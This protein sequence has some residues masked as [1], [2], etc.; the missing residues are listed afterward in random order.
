MFVNHPRIVAAAVL[1]AMAIGTTAPAYAQVPG[2]PDLPVAPPGA[3]GEVLDP[4]EDLIGEITGPLGDLVGDVPLDNAVTLMGED[5]VEAAVALS[6]I[7]FE[8]SEFAFI[9]RDDVFADTLSS[10]AG[11]G[12]A[13]APLLLT[14]TDAVDDRTVAELDRLGVTRV[15]LLGAGQALSPFVQQRFETAYGADNVTRIG[16]PSRIETAA[17]LAAEL[18]PSTPH[19]VMLRAYPEEGADQSQAYAD[20]LSVGPLASSLELPSLLTTTDYLHPATRAYL[21]SAGV[22][23]VTMIGGESAIA[24]AVEQTLSSMGITVDRIAGETRWSTSILVANAMG[25]LDASEANRIILTEGGS[26]EQPLWAAG[27]AAAAQGAVF[28]SPV[29]L[30]DGPL[31][32]PETL[33]FFADGLIANALRLSN[34]PLICNSFVDFLACETAALLMVG[35]LDEANALTGG[36]LEMVLGPVFGP[37][38]EALDGVIPGAGEM[39]PG[40]VGGIVGLIGVPGDDSE[41]EGD[42]CSDGIDNDGDGEI[43]E[44]DECEAAFATF[45]TAQPPAVQDAV[46]RMIG[47]PGQR[48]SASRQV[49]LIEVLGD[50]RTALGGPVMT[51]D[52]A[53]A[54]ALVRV[55]DGITAVLASRS[56]DAPLEAL[57]GLL[58]GVSDL[59]DELAD[60]VSLGQAIDRLGVDTSDVVDDLT[61]TVG[62]VLTGASGF[63]S[64]R[65]LTDRYGE[66]AA[67]LADALE[68][69]VDN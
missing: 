31:L 25:V 28:E 51:V 54:D 48:I 42:F 34:E 20:A 22:T 33:A 23:E 46:Q 24:P 60:V 9:G 52:P 45:M 4:I 2:L 55:L 8:T 59:V 53:Q 64:S 15:I 13:G 27:F 68:E 56:T 29:I 21:E 57:T 16:G 35:L 50:L 5:A 10:V 47:A 19:V 40:L 44:A 58:V 37:L 36:A 67:P 12:I 17:D 43:D 32:P 26:V 62:S 18:A 61:G 6:R 11:Q 49:V 69:L 41:P 39:S 63:Q 14:Q 66:A 7:T 1:A 38:A 3:I 30:A 65:S